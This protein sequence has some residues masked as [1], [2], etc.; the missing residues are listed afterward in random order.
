MWGPVLGGRHQFR[1]PFW[2]AAI[3][4]K[5]QFLILGP[6]FKS[7]SFMCISEPPLC[8]I[9]STALVWVLVSLFWVPSFSLSGTSLQ[10]GSS[11][12]SLDPLGINNGSLVINNKEVSQFITPN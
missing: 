1:D 6:F 2:G 11:G 7:L 3:N 10:S 5:T 8:A 12:F 9:L 4:N